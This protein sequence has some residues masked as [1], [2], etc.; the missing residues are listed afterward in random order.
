MKKI[1]Q[2][3]SLSLLVIM[4]FAPLFTGC[5]NRKE[6]KHSLDVVSGAFFFD[7]IP[8][9]IGSVSLDYSRLP[10]GYWEQRLQL[11]KGLGVNTIMVRVPWMLHEPQEG[12]FCFDGECDVREFC[13]L[14][15]ENGLLVWLHVGPYV[16]AHL[17]MGGMPWWLLKD[18]N[19]SL[20]SRQKLFMDKVGRYFHALASELADMQL[21]RGGN[22]SL[23]HIEEPDGLQ[24]NHKAYL[25]ALCDS[26]R[27]AGF[28]ETLLTVVTTKENV[29]QVPVDKALAAYSIGD[30]QS[31]M[32]N[33]AGAR[34][35]NPNSPV[36]CFDV[37]RS[38]NHVWGERVPRRN[39]DKTFARMFE[40]FEGSGSANVSVALGGTSFGHLSG[41]EIMDGRFRPFS[42]TYD[43]N[44][45][46]NESGRY[47]EAITMFREAFH[48]SATQVLPA[49]IDTAEIFELNMFPETVVNSYSPLFENLPQ[50]IA[51]EQPL[52]FEQC[53]VGHG[54]VLYSA[55]L[56]KIEEGS[57]LSFDA[58][59][60]NAQIFIGGKRV[61]QLSRL[62]GDSIIS[63][64]AEAS[65]ATIDILVDAF[66]RV[67]NVFGYKDYKGIVGRVFLT[68]ARGNRKALVGWENTPIAADY[69][70]A[71]SRPF[72]ALKSVGQPGYYR[73]T[74]TLPAKGDFYLYMGTWGRGEVWINGHSL[75]RFW[76]RGP[77]RTLYVPGC[78]LKEKDNELLILDYVGPSIPVVEGFKSAILD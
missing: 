72:G 73:T 48:R 29:H 18:K 2:R 51:S 1:V 8:F 68:D 62:S 10:R 25:A 11:I 38:C 22:I 37:A 53:G 17:D 76:S 75:G 52:T 36:L 19:I 58:V 74:F 63:L 34:K 65:D 67:A 6:E 47:R 49:K 31:A 7:S 78:W 44:S 30:K 71:S 21:S 16:D 20:R 45:I 39:L 32:S 3:V 46:F 61:A 33:F 15:Q 12:T 26:V 57:K 14:A 60:D 24:P 66:G 23:I 9:K 4:L 69:N 64:S 70:R 59:H 13:S 5:D 50:A 55:T 54:A 42:T 43:N 77:Q 35:H 56:P 40:V 27:S 41:A 28:S